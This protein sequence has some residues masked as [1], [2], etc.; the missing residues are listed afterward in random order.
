[1]LVIID[2]HAYRTASI[3]YSGHDESRTAQV[4]G[5]ASASDGR[6]DSLDNVALNATL[7]L[8]TEFRR[9]SSIYTTDEYTVLCLYMDVNKCDIS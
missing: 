3:V 9:T 4:L 5:R 8:Y 7:T 1:M 6:A 2:K